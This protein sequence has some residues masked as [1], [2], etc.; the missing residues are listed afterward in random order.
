MSFNLRKLVRNK[1]HLDSI[2]RQDLDNL[3]NRLE[4]SKKSPHYNERTHVDVEVHLLDAMLTALEG[5]VN[6]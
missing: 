1:R 4:A 2:R 3:R 6:P 5:M